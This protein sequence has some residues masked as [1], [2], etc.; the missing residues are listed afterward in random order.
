MWR[1]ELELPL[2]LRWRVSSLP[3]SN[4]MW[5]WAFMHWPP[6]ETPV[7]KASG[8]VSV[9][10]GQAGPH[11]TWDCSAL[12]SYLSPAKKNQPQTLQV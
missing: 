3:R 12:S 4:P 10:P 5:F 9:H 1:V 11:V 6:G 2:L 8:M 7:A